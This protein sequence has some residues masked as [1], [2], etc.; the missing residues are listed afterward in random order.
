MNRRD[1][2]KTAGLTAAGASLLPGCTPVGDDKFEQ[3][4][5]P[6]PEGIIPGE[7]IYLSTTCMECPANCGVSAKNVDGRTIKLEGIIGHPINDGGLCVRGQA[8]ITRLYHPKRYKSPMRRTRNG[9]FDAITWEEAYRSV[10]SAL[11]TDKSGGRSSVYLSS[12][13]TGSLSTF[14]DRFCAALGVSRLPELEVFSHSAVRQANQT[15]FGHKAIPTYKIDRADFLLTVGA[16]L[17]ETFVSPVEHAKKISKG[18]DT[19]SFWWTHVEPHISIEA[20]SADTRLA[21]KPGT[22][23]VLL[24]YL[25]QQF[26]GSV[27]GQ[28]PIEAS[29]VVE[30]VGLSEESLTKLVQRMREARR[31]LVIAGGVSVQHEKGLE[32]AVLAAQLQKQLGSAAEVMDFNSAYNY[33]NVGSLLDAEVWTKKL[34]AGEIGVIFVSKTDP[35]LTLPKPLGFAE[36]FK[37]ATL[38]V[39]LSEI[40]NKTLDECDIILP[41]SHFLES[42]GD[43]EPRK[44]LR[45]I[46]QPTREQLF[47]TKSE[48]DI[49]LDLLQTAGKPRPKNFRAFIESEWARLGT[50]LTP[51]I[52]KAGFVAT[53]AAAAKPAAGPA[54]GAGASPVAAGAAASVA[55]SA[56]PP[57]P[58]PLQVS[59]ADGLSAQLEGDVLV[60]T[61]SLRFYDGRSRL[62][63]LN[64]QGATLLEEIPEPVSTISYGEWISVRGWQDVT[65]EFVR[66]LDQIEITLGETRLQP[67]ALKLQPRLPDSV[68]MVERPFLVAPDL[69]IDRRTGEPI[70]FSP[71][72]KWRGAGIIPVAVMSGSPSQEGRGIIPN[73]VETPGEEAAAHHKSQR[74]DGIVASEPELPGEHEERL[75]LYPEHVH[76]PYRWG[77]TIDL[78]KCTGCSACVAACYVENNI[79]LVGKD[80]HLNGREMSWIRIE[81]YF[82]GEA[83]GDFIPMLCQQCDSA[84]CEPVCPVYAA[85]HNPDGL[86]GQ[87]YNRCVG[88]RYCANNCPY[89]VRRFNWINYEWESPLDQ[90]INPEVSVRGRGVMEKCTFCVQRIR[91]GKDHAKDENRLVRDGEIQP[92]CV[93]TCP[94][95]AIQFGNM[96]DE[97][98]KMMQARKTDRAYR[99]FESLGTEP[100]VTYL[101]DVT[102]EDEVSIGNA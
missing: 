37:K 59:F 28:G 92:A 2:I 39:G 25:L 101:A 102:K 1:F 32:V 31:P 21:C 95:D 74:M 50:P 26:G 79:P 5:Y 24:G 33:D 47:N 54:T 78:D 15:V 67:L 51:D 56:T 62:L 75:T 84:P 23:A 73:A 71:N 91:A 22:E 97:N 42:W 96:L 60:V 29:S 30:Q 49:L 3:A 19:G 93:Q 61:P 89:K 53:A 88:T 77:M 86:N 68:Y 85:Y 66:G 82:D 69:G 13:T 20:M 7:P 64:A 46:I 81:P 17:L 63:P 27:S 98:S 99:V 58:A 16:D 45:T 100:A 41:L 9:D 57:H 87:I 76:Q 38:R 80:A 44:G 6:A 72:L 36:G 94:S 65:G 10:W 83:R 70:S 14:I 4:L 18:K 90:M 8:T 48:G 11:Q 34:N 55:A 43:A 35:A 12:R 52:M 40:S